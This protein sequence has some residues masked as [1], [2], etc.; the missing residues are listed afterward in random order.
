M[1]TPILP[2]LSL[3]CVAMGNPAETAES[4]LPNRLP[5]DQI[6]ILVGP[7]AL[8][9]DTLVALILPASTRP[10]EIVLAARLL[11][12][13]ENPDAI[14]A[15]PWEE[16]VKSLCRYPEVIAYL[17]MN[18]A[19][20]QSLGDCFLIQPVEVMDAIQAVRARAR[21]KG[22][23]TDTNEQSVVVEDGEIRIIP[24]RETVIFVPHYDSDYLYVTDSWYPG[25][26]LS[27]GIGYSIG[28]WL[29]YDCDWRYHRVR[30]VQRGPDWYR[31]P[32]W[33]TRPAYHQGGNHVRDWSA[34]RPP[35]RH[36]R[37]NGAPSSPVLRPDH[38]WTDPNHTR[39]DSPGH[40]RSND[41]PTRTDPRPHV[42][43]NQPDFVQSNTSTPP[44]P[45]PRITNREN[46]DSGPRP[47]HNRTDNNRPGNRSPGHNR[48]NVAN[49]TPTYTAPALS[50]PVTP[51]PT[52]VYR[53]PSGDHRT[54]RSERRNDGVG[55]AP[56][57]RAAADAPRVHA[58]SPPPAP[59]HSEGVDRSGSHQEHRPAGKPAGRDP[60]PEIE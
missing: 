21:A 11:E 42:S 14:A 9:P 33:R 18:L 46:R 12:R 35:S 51:Q 52:T 59:R 49:G 55:P 37:T 32:N 36:H 28:A 24:A 2:F 20:T 25:P 26:F 23:L 41:R 38:G 22:L 8:Y 27:F 19:W 40:R 53:Q 57:E 58:P 54:P 5:R 4:E 13:G 43:P 45:R 1:K 30:I 60:N 31:S 10:S 29:S 17:N 3:V 39:V 56:R 16:S 15:Q 48:P 6:E 50:T 7:I 47:D 44:Q 34:S